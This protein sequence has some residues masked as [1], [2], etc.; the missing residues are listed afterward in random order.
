M[1]LVVMSSLAML[2]ATPRRTAR[3]RTRSP[4]AAA[5]HLNAGDDQVAQIIVKDAVSTW[6]EANQSEFDAH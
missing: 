2:A 3:S 1:R 4:G 6:I 5:K